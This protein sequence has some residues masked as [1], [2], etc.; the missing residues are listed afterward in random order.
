MGAVATPFLTERSAANQRAR[1]SRVGSY[2]SAHM[3]RFIAWWFLMKI[4]WGFGSRREAGIQGGFVEKTCCANG[5]NSNASWGAWAS[6][7][8]R[9]LNLREN[10][11]YFR[12]L[13]GRVIVRLQVLVFRL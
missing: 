8:G 2:P 7:V 1:H 6:P 10:M 12:S 11:F 3:L 5:S 9:C 4:N 13:C